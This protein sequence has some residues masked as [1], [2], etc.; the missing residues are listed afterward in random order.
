MWR[1]SF[2][3]I[4]KFESSLQ[5]YIIVHVYC[6]VTLCWHCA[7]CGQVTAAHSCGV[8]GRAVTLG[9]TGREAGPFVGVGLASSGRSEP[10]GF[11]D[12]SG[13][14]LKRETLGLIPVN[15]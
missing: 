9:S 2:Y 3:E 10:L 1:I 6:V 14:D 12:Y 4:G 5:V 13:R 7:R 15:A 11:S 8:K